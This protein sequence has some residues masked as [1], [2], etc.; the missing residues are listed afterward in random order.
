MATKN[1]EDLAK[2]S[3]VTLYRFLRLDLKFMFKKRKFNNILIVR[4]TEKFFNNCAI[5]YFLLRCF[6]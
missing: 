2:I 3:L 5:M 6:Y 1:N 4:T